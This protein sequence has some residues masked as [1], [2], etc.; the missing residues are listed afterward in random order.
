M[1]RDKRMF[2]S[3]I[4]KDMKKPFG[5]IKNQKYDVETYE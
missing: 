2:T 5:E 1:T 4:E 3:L